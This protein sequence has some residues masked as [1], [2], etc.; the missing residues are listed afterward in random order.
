M[1]QRN[2]LISNAWCYEVDNDVF[3]TI[4]GFGVGVLLYRAS[5][6]APIISSE[7]VGFDLACS[8]CRCWIPLLLRARTFFAVFGPDRKAIAQGK[9]RRD[10]GAIRAD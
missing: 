7:Q 1:A 9:A 5:A 8:C 6:L 4:V 3:R 2:S 10:S